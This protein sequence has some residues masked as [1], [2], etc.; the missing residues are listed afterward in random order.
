L[1]ISFCLCNFNFSILHCA[2]N[3]RISVALCFSHFNI[4]VSFG[5]CFSYF[6][7]TVLLGNTFFGFINGFSSGFFAQ[8]FEIAR[9]IANIGY[10]YV[11][12]FQTYF[13][14]FGFHVG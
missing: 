14:Q 12:E 7:K 11:D 13:S 10:V 3:H 8:C 4:A 5:F 6:A 9:F 1:L 2:C